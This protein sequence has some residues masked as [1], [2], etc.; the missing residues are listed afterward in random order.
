MPN[1]NPTPSK[2]GCFLQPSKAITTTT[3][4]VVPAD[5]GKVITN[6][7]A[8]GNLNV[9]LPAPSAAFEGCWVKFFSVAAGTFTI[10]CTD[11][12][13]AENTVVGD[14]VAFAQASEIIGNGV[15]AVC[16]GS[17]WFVELH[18]GSTTATHVVTAA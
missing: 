4:T 3:Y 5:F 16:T 17:K 7:G 2:F 11:S 9:T 14:S 18:L 15:M 12:L 1:I 13:I 8:S 10:T 6:R